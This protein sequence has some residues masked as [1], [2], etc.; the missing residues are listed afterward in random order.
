MKGFSKDTIHIHL[1]GAATPVGESFRCQTASLGFDW[2]IHSY[3]RRSQQNFDFVKPENFIPCGDFSAPSIWVNFGPIWLF[4]RFLDFLA[5]A[6]PEYISSLKGVISCSS[7]SVVTKRFSFNSFDRNLVSLLEKSED[8]LIEVCQRFE[9]PCRILQPTLIYG[10]AGT[11]EDK[12]L[13]LLLQSLRR[14]PILPVPSQPG[15]R[16]PIHAN[17]LAAISLDLAVKISRCRLD[18]SFPLRIP[19]G[20]DS[21]LTYTQMIIDLQSS[22]SS[23]DPARHCRLIPIPNRLYFLAATLLLIC[24]PKSYEAVLRIAANLCGFTAVHELLG[25]DPEPFPVK[26]Q[27]CD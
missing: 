18:P 14:L 15:L 9:V 16:Q 13:S 6:S 21:T 27:Y 24:S 10:K 4:A 8:T 5:G 2:Q 22:Q 3:S 7:S 23:N 19:V 12:N 1:F 25:C 17:Q 20:G 26:N 11:Y